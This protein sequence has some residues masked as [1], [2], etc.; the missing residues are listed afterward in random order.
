MFC[1]STIVFSSRLVNVT[2]HEKSDYHCGTP[3]GQRLNL[4]R[5]Q[6]TIWPG[7]PDHITINKD[8]RLARKW[9]DLNWR[10]WKKRLPRYRLRA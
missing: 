9:S 1:P 2:R 7:T 5:Y 4:L 3:L 10:I 6:I 8:G